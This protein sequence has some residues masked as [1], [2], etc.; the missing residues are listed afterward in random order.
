MCCLL[1]PALNLLWS[2]FEGLDQSLSG[3]H[4]EDF[5]LLD[6]QVFNGQAWAEE[7]VV[8]AADSDAQDVDEVGVGFF[9]CR[10]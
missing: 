10:R 4:A 9:R 7:E 6:A 3:G 2:F 5:Y 1:H 8:Y